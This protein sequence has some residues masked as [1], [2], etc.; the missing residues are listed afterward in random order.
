MSAA[1]HG[2][3]VD[4]D[5]VPDRHSDV[6]VIGGG[7]AGLSAAYFLQR[8]GL[9]NRY[10]LLDH[11]PGP[12]G[13]WQFRWPTLTLSGTNRVHDLPGYGLNEAVGVD[14]DEFPASTVVP[15]YF[16]RYE[17]KFGLRVR[18]P[19]DVRS[20]EREGD[21]FRA[22]LGG[23]LR[24]QVITARTLIN[25]TGTWERPFI[26]HIPGAET[27]RG[28]QLHTH[29]YT[30]PEEFAGQ[31]VLVVGAGISAV[32]L[33]IEIARQA[34][35]VRTFWCS[36]TRPHFDPHP[37]SPEL[38]REAVARVER[39]VR[40]G[41]PPTS[42]VSVT[43]LAL[44]PA[45]EAAQRDGILD[46]WRPMFTRITETGVC[47]DCGGGSTGA[48]VSAGEHLDVDVIFW[49]T[50]FRSALDHLSP[51]HLR[52]PGGGIVMTGRLATTVA[53][54]PRIQLIGYGPSASTIGA[55]RAGREAARNV[56]DILAAS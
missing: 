25:A 47:W 4:A 42:V 48:E 31:R 28:K 1:S 44:T 18:R 14:R 37:F 2:T 34:P 50:G 15:E 20:V 56:A 23:R 12:G 40:A 5:L 30:G 6:L 17:Q 11:S 26:P 33:L 22:T 49:N 41:L 9:E 13:A 32:G 51:L 53:D 35:G 43:G 19:V 10:Q 8:F 3:V 55:N 46:E 21:V 27:F 7:Q 16:A 29:D 39:R 45:I 52:G 38:G 54:D 36:R 24:G